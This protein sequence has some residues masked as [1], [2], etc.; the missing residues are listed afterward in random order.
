[1][2][3]LF[4]WAVVLIVALA[5]L[6]G[7]RAW[8]S[9]YQLPKITAAMPWSAYEMDFSAEKASYAQMRELL[10]TRLS[11]PVLP[12]RDTAAADQAYAYA[13]TQPSDETLYLQAAVRFNP[14]NLAYG[15]ALRMHMMAAGKGEELMQFLHEMDQSV[16]QIKLQE[17]LTYVDMLQEPT[18]GT[19]SLGQLSFKSIEALNQILAKNPFDWKAHYA[20]GINN[21][22][23]P[24]G[25]KRIDKSIQDLA[26]CVTVA[27]QFDNQPSVLWPMAYLALG[28]ALVKKGDVQA[29][30]S[31]WKEGLKKSPLD[32]DL[33]DR[34]K[35]GSE[36]ALQKVAETRGMEQFQR[37]APGMTDFNQIWSK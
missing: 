37:P 20:R 21:L 5:A 27:E 10:Q 2:R 4:I 18:L 26:F 31:I 32:P 23:W 1:M 17:A 8:T 15:T 28:D 35:G 33:R 11:P 6:W 36:Q 7:Y 29:G 19:A 22:Y 24:L 12:V 30:V 25:L 13:N 14:R 34:V 9:P 3:K 16:P